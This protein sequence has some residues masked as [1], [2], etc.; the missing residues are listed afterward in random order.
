MLAEWWLLAYLEHGCFYPSATDKLP[1]RT[2][3]CAERYFG[4]T[5]SEQEFLGGLATC[6]RNGWLRVVDQVAVDEVHALLR[7]NPAMWPVLGEAERDWGEIDFTPSGAAL[8]RMIAAEWLGPDWEDDLQ[9]RKE[10]FRE[11]HRYCEADEELRAVAE[12]CTAQGEIVRASK[13]LAIGP[14]CVFWWERFPAGY[15][16]ELKI[17]DL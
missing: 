9:V 17:G 7:N 5:I 12:E 4:L 1:R 6:L 15:R 16:L 2:A 10:S 11:E 8:Y 3:E 14:W 13:L